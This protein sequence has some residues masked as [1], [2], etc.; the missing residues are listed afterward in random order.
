MSGEGPASRVPDG[1]SP[2][3]FPVATRTFVA[4]DTVVA[5]SAPMDPEELAAVVQAVERVF[6]E[7]AHRMPGG[8]DLKA[9]LTAR[10]G[11]ALM[12]LALPHWAVNAGG[13]ILCTGSPSP[14]QPTGGDPYYGTPWR[15]GIADSIGGSSLVADV[16]LAGTPGFTAAL[17]TSADGRRGAY[18][19]VSVLSEDIVAAGRAAA[20]ILAGGPAALAAAL[21]EPGLAVLAVRHGGQVLASNAWPLPARGREGAGE[22]GDPRR[23]P[24][25]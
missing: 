22:T 23:G 25:A 2:L 7:D 9:R 6:T 13:D 24:E 10:T 12:D 19:Q 16:P 5:V 8:A 4:V 18:R 3:T 15:A 1:S 21:R 20:V 11:R 14:G 17:A